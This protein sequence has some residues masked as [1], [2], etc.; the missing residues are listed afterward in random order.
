MGS[1]DVP[2][3]GNNAIAASVEA[4]DD[5]CVELSVGVGTVVVEIHYSSKAWLPQHGS[6]HYFAVCSD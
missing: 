1:H 3:W 6:F 2:F 5:C 4:V